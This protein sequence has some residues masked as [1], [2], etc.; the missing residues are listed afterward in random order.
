MPRSFYQD[1]TFDGVCKTVR[2]RFHELEEH[3]ALGRI[4]PLGELARTT[5]VLFFTHHQHLVSI[6]E[7]ALAPLSS[8]YPAVT[9]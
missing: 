8:A 9:N 4:R 3:I 5:Q 6:A 1:L 7:N 2:I